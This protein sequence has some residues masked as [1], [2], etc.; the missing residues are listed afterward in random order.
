MCAIFL[1]LWLSLILIQLEQLY[2]V[3]IVYR[4]SLVWLLYHFLLGI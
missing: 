1:H 3:G 2:P 4:S